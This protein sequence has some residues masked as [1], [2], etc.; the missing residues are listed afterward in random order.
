VDRKGGA[1][2]VDRHS[3]GPSSLGPF[4]DRIAAAPYRPPAGDEH[5]SL[6]LDTTSVEIFADDGLTVGTFQY[7]T[8]GPFEKLVVSEGAGRVKIRY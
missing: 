5:L 3:C 1:I 8:D 2:T 4:F 6:L 7:F